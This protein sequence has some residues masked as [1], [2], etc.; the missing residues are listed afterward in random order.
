MCLG[1]SLR[2]FKWRYLLE[3]GFC[4]VGGIAFV[5]GVFQMLVQ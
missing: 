1:T 2:I 5:A 4:G 3:G